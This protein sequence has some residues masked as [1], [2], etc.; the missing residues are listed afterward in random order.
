MQSNVLLASPIRQR[1]SLLFQDRLILT[2]ESL[3]DCSI[4]YILEK[5]WNIFCSVEVVRSSTAQ[6]LV[7]LVDIESAVPYQDWF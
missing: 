6:T 5:L 7:V 1:W 3:T 4:F 2:Y